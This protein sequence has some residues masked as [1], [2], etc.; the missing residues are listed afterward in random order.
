MWTSIHVSEALI[1]RVLFFFHFFFSE[2]ICLRLDLALYVK[3]YTS[4]LSYVVFLIDK[5]YLKMK[6][7]TMIQ[8]TNM[9][10]FCVVVGF[11]VWPPF[12]WRLKNLQYYF[13]FS[14]GVGRD[15]PRGSPQRSGGGQ[16]FTKRSR[17]LC[18]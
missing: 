4:F 17:A 5:L 13:L 10:T 9:V 14:I 11:G 1:V 6:P 2:C 15:S 7:H 18:V 8:R 16:P 3:R 12:Y